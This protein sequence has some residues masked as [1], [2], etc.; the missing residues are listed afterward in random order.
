MTKTKK[1]PSRKGR[2]KERK[3]RSKKLQKKMSKRIPRRLGNE[4]NQRTRSKKRIG[5]VRKNSTAS[6]WRDS[7]RTASPKRS[8]R[9][10][11]LT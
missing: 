11:N 8:R 7:Q 4:R 10:W 5:A 3:L 9:M 6:S 1:K 2:D